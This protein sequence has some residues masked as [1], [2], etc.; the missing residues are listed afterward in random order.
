MTS[1][2]H[3]RASPLR[4]ELSP[5]TK[6]SF[7]YSFPSAAVVPDLWRTMGLC[8]AQGETCLDSVREP[9]SGDKVQR[10]RR[11]AFAREPRQRRGPRTSGL[12]CVCSWPPPWRSIMPPSEVSSEIL[13]RERPSRNRGRY[14]VTVGVDFRACEF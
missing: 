4:I 1:S 14:T 2:T 7:S 13:G 5:R 8:G 3:E 11:G 6:Y 9:S 10:T 12:A